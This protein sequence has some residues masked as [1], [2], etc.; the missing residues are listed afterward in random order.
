MVENDGLRKGRHCVFDMHAHLV[1][2]TKYRH[3]VFT[4]EHLDRLGRIFSD[5]CERFGC[6]L[7]E[8]NGEVDHV[9]LLV[10]FPPTVQ[11]SRLVNSLKGVSSR[12]MRRDYPELARHYW[13]AQRLWSAS[14]YAGTNGGAPLETLRRYIENQNRPD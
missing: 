12:Y 14:Y 11:I 13:R 7:D 1:F 8:F 4:G 9:H 10:S 3:P 6:H 2:V 5:V